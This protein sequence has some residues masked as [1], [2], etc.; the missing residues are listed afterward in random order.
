MQSIRAFTQGFR[1]IFQPQIRW[2]AFTPLLINLLIYSL[3]AGWLVV[4]FTAL[5]DWAMK[6]IPSWLD[7]LIPIAWVLFSLCILVVFG[8]SFAIIGSIIASPFNGLLAEKIAEQVTGGKI[9]PEAS[10]NAVLALVRKSLWREIVKLAYFLPRMTL[11]LLISLVLGPI[12]VIGLVVSTL[13]FIWAAW[14]MSIQYLDYPADNAGIGF[15]QTLSQ[16]KKKRPDCIIF[17]AAVTFAMSIPLLNLLA[18]PA[19]VAGATLLWVEEL[20]PEARGC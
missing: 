18:I 5:L 8:F 13:V 1:L 4:E 17:G 10:F 3:L 2:L 19:A 20:S 12:P 11:F 6:R 16:M 15:K 14:S 9:P 7:F